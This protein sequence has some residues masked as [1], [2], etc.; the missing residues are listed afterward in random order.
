MASQQSPETRAKISASLR[1]KPKTAEHRAAIGRANA[2]AL[3]GRRLSVEHRAAIA[4]GARRRM[5]DPDERARVSGWH[6]TP[7]TKE[8]IGRGVRESWEARRALDTVPVAGTDNGEGGD[9]A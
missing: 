2:K 4:E 1:G 3:R 8:R 6:H 9:D 5:A 7:E